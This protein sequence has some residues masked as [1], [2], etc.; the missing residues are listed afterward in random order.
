MIL[1]EIENS[2]IKGKTIPQS[3]MFSDFSYWWFVYPVIYPSVQQAINFIDSLESILDEKKP[4]SIDMK[5]E[6][7]KLKIMKQICDKQKIKLRYAKLNYWKFKIVDIIFLKIQKY[8]FIQITKEKTRKRLCLSKI[9]G[10]IIPDLK[11]KIVFAVS[12]AYRREIY[13][14]EK[15]TSSRGEYIVGPI[16]DI[17]KKLGK[18]VIGLDLDY[19]FRGQDKILEERLND[20]N[21]HWFPIEVLS[22]N[23]FSN[24][25][26]KSYLKNYLKIL[27]DRDFQSLFVYRGINFWSMIRNDFK[28]LSFFPHLPTYLDMTE[29]LDHIFMN[30]KPSVIFVPYETGPLALA[31]IVAAQ[32]NGVKTIGLQHGMILEMNSDYSH[33]NFRNEKN[34]AGMILPD[35]LLL[36]GDYTRNILLKNKLYPKEKLVAFGNP[37]YFNMENVKKM[38]FSKIKNKHN[39]PS[40]KKI[41][42]FTTS[43]YQRY[44]AR[45]KNQNYDEQILEKLIE[46]FTNKEEYHIVL[47][48]HPSEEYLKF[49]ED[50]I[51][52]NH[53]KNF[54]IVQGDLMELLSI[55]DVVVC[56]FST[57]LTDAISLGKMTIQ[58]KF[59]SSNTFIPFLEYGVHVITDLQSVKKNVENL[60]FDMQLQT[61]IRSKMDV[62]LKEYFNLPNHDVI[63]QMQLLTRAD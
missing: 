33:H 59:D 27:N 4:T 39:I 11:N 9:K 48:P 12:T 15:Q 19:T 30:N 34:L 40:N 25:K 57:I 32:H 60:I 31:L 23:S 10:N 16:I 20:D 61:E 45:F 37:M 1:N 49:Y 26:V 18:N 35:F 46:E 50:L 41:I 47:K 21:I 43:T 56:Y 63:E 5:G 8:R 28:K 24:N 44:Y 54:S 51:S 29:S 2:K 55:S 36:F 3:F 6:F 38:D 62:F 53:C 52:K 58:V 17:L 14:F 42:L 22:T 7:Q 13:D